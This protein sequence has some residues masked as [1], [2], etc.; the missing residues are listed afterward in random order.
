MVIVRHLRKAKSITLET[1]SFPNSDRNQHLAYKELQ[2]ISKLNDQIEDDNEI[3]LQRSIH[4]Q[5]NILGLQD[6]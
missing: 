3:V 1:K 5:W 6:T 2:E 4:S